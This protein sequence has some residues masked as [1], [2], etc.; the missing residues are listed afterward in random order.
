[1][2]KVFFKVMQK[3]YHVGEEDLKFL[4]FMLFIFKFLINFNLQEFL[5][6]KVQS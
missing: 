4:A 2:L 3:V 5:T 6:I 1:M